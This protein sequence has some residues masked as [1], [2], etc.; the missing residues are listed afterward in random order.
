VLETD[1]EPARVG[2]LRI[3]H[4]RLHLVFPGYIADL[5][6]W[7]RAGD[8]GERAGRVA[9]A[10]LVYVT[11]HHGCAFLDAPLGSGESDTRSRRCGDQHDIEQTHARNRDQLAEQQ[12]QTTD[13]RDDE[14]LQCTHLAFSDDTD[15]RQ[16]KRCDQ[17]HIG[18]DTRHKV[19]AIIEIGI[20]PG[21]LLYRD[22][23]A[24]PG[25]GLDV[26]SDRLTE[27]THD[28]LCTVGIRSVRD[29]LHLPVTIEGRSDMD[30]GADP[31][32]VHGR[33]GLAHIGVVVQG[34]P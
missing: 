17:H 3:I 11:D 4:Q 19:G 8:L 29:Q 31:V 14:T 18:H 13:R 22:R 24:H 23:R 25:R 10:S 7:P 30:D 20:E 32:A 15:R 27:L 28:H 33:R 1:A 6:R 5:G 12:L 9:Q 34:K 26:A 16:E 2:Q 21:A